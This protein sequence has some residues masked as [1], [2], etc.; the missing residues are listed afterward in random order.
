MIANSH[1]SLSPRLGVES[2]AW[3]KR[4]HDF[5]WVSCVTKAFPRFWLNFVRYESSEHL[6]LRFWL[7]KQR[8]R[9][10]CSQFLVEFRAWRSVYTILIES[11]AWRKRF[12]D[13]GWVSCVTKAFPRFWLK[14]VRG[15]SPEHLFLRFWLN[16]RK[17]R[18]FCSRFLVEFRAWRKSFH[19]FGW[20]SCMAKP[21]PRFW[22]SLVHGETVSTILVESH[23]WRKRFHDF[24]WILCMAKAFPKFWLN[25]VR[26]ESSEHCYH[27]FS[28]ILCVTKAQIILFS[29]LVK[30]CTFTWRKLKK[31]VHNFG[32]ITCVTKFLLNF[33]RDESE[34]H[35]H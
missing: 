30:L 29:I 13:F 28:W 25:F 24:G 20:I 3:R 31:Y 23:S 21:F 14:F 22:L 1:L 2:R 7:N 9:S 5:G 19:D 17:R 15:E 32:W 26:D 16:K 18:S 27:D 6:F 11:S 10:F 35:F 12:H 33:A 4:F 8:R 34:E